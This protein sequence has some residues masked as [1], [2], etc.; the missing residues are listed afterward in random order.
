VCVCVCVCVYICSIK[1]YHLLGRSRHLG[2]D[3]GVEKVLDL[4]SVRR[5][6]RY[7]FLLE[8]SHDLLALFALPAR[9]GGR[10]LLG[11]LAGL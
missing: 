11:A 7:H 4:D 5:V 10:R 3:F 9:R 1:A 6:D 8:L 2:A